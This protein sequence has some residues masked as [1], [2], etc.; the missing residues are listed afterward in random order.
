MC[1]VTVRRARVLLASPLIIYNEKR[2]LPHSQNL[3]WNLNI[4]GRD[5]RLRFE[6]ISGRRRSIIIFQSAAEGAENCRRE[7]RTIKFTKNSGSP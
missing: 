5:D 6:E 4:L 3:L 7:R 2:R 1:D